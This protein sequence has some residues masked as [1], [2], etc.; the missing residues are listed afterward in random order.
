MC[1][2]C[3]AEG[4]GYGDVEVGVGAG[5]AFSVFWSVWIM[6]ALGAE[7]AGVCCCSTL[8]VETFAT[9]VTVVTI[10]ALAIAGT[11]AYWRRT[12]VVLCPS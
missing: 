9:T 12:A 10:R 2:V 7:G 4:A 1:V 3:I 11:G 5:P 6:V 8:C